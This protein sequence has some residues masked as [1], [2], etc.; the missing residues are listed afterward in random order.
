MSFNVRNHLS[1]DG[2]NEWKLRSGLLFDVV[3]NH[4]PDLLGTQEAYWPQVEQMR[5]ALPEYEVVGVGRDDGVT[6]G[7][8][9]ALFFRHDRFRASASGT[10][11][12]SDTPDVP[13][14]RHWT[15]RHARIC[16]W[17]RL[18]DPSGTRF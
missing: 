10:F 1:R 17:A 18:I 5:D 11:W 4:Q 7:E 8:T 13:G 15:P 9:C 14:S 6:E 3:R 2:D 12:F 16:T